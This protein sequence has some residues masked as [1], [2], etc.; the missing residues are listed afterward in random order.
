MT[1]FLVN[2]I[3]ISLVFL[4]GCVGETVT[5]KSGHLNLGI[6]GIMCM[7]TLGGS[8]GVAIYMNGLQDVGSASM[9][10][11]LLSTLFFAMLFA[12]AGGLIYAFLTVTL[13]CNQNITG[14]AITTFGEGIT[15]FFM[16]EIDKTHFTAAS[17]LLRGSLLDAFPALEKLGWFGE[18][19]LSHG[20]LLYIGIALAVVTALVLRKSRMGLNLRAVGESPA[21]AD[22]AGINVTAYK[23]GA[24]LS[25]AAIAGLGGLFYVMDSAAGSWE[26]S[27]TISAF[28]WLAIALVIFAVWQPDIAIF[29]SFV[30]GLLYVFGSY[31]SLFGIITSLAGRELLKLLPYV[32]TIIV[33]IVTSIAGKKETQPP[34]SLGLNYFREER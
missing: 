23:Y 4:Y 31:S 22:A 33:L 15:D 27:S 28:G 1:A 3:N 34:A 7:G 12:A 16:A 24:I 10:L 26:N 17:N 11:L 19:F 18:I 30:F 21:T 13:R 14:L 29:G 8:C 2:A 6:P 5:E 20:I 9:I 32:I 25:G